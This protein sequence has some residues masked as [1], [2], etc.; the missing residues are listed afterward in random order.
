MKH[1][2]HFSLLAVALLC[3]PLCSCHDDTTLGMGLQDPSTL[4]DGIRDTFLV[5]AQTLHTDSL[6]TSGNSYVLVGQMDDPTFG[7]TEATAYLQVTTGDNNGLEFDQYCTIDSIVLGLYA[8]SIY[9]STASSYPLHIR[10]HQLAEPVLSDTSYYYFDTLRAEGSPLFDST[11]TLTHSDTNRLSL[12]LDPSLHTLLEG[13]SYTSSEF[14]EAFKGLRVSLVDDGNPLMVT[15]NMAASA[16][17]IEVYYHYTNAGEERNL[18]RTLSIGVLN[19]HF[20][21]YT[22]NY[23]GALSRF[24]TNLKDSL[25]G[26]STIYMDPL[27][28]TYARLDFNAYLDT[29]R[30]KHPYATIHRAELLLPAPDADTN[31][32]PTRLLALRRNANGTTSYIADIADTYVGGGY[33]GTYDKTKKRYRMRITRHIQQLLR[34]GHDYGTNIIVDSRI[35]TPKHVAT[36]GYDPT[37]TASNPIRV[38]LIYSEK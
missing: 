15:L 21:H 22:H 10:V 18:I 3:W 9:P 26:S 1:H 33:D 34:N 25:D 6:I 27:A 31:I 11:I 36:N 35:I 14:R 38:V 12:R 19:A 28:G 24:N 8:Q 5:K 17:K 7:R 4:F 37:A 13:H 16:S 32:I 2:L 30:T 23:T 20:T 29:F